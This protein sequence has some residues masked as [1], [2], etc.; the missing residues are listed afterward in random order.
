MVREKHIKAILK[1]RIPRHG[2]CGFGANKKAEF[3]NENVQ[4]IFLAGGR[5]ERKIANQTANKTHT[6]RA[7]TSTAAAAC[8]TVEA[9]TSATAAAA[10]SMRGVDMRWIGDVARRRRSRHRGN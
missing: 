4:N 9:R 6:T 1:S 7:S 5:C 3:E 2:A 8:A 10:R